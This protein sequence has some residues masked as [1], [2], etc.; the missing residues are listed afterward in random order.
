MASVFLVRQRS[1]HVA[2]AG[3]VVV[4]QALQGHPAHWPVLVVPQAMVVHGEQ[5]SG[6]GVVC[7]LHLHAV[8]N[9][10]ERFAT[11]H[12]NIMRPP[13]LL[14]PCVYLASRLQQSEF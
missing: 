6:Q 2:G 13:I 10:V 4:E 5:V 3:E 1:H 7:D 9:A 14:R 8:V 11:R 12:I